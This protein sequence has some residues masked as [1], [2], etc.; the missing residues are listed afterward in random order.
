MRHR[1]RNRNLWRLYRILLWSGQQQ[2]NVGGPEKSPKRKIHVLMD[3]VRNRP[4]GSTGA[5][6]LL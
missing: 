1:W 4:S 5:V 6:R 2:Q 3:L